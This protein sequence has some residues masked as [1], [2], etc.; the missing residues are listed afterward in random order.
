M[1]PPISIGTVLQNRYRVLQVL[2]QGG[3]G[4]TYL[5]AD[6]GRFNEYC[7]LKEFIP[8]QTSDYAVAKSNELFEREASV[9]YQI[10]HPQVPKFQAIFEQDQRLFLIQD[11]VEGKSYNAL[12]GERIA[13]G[14]AFTPEETQRFVQQLLPVLAHIHSKGIIHRD[15]SPDNVMLRQ[16]D[17]QPVL[18]DFGV[19]KAVAT[20]LQSDMGGGPTTVGK[21]GYAPNEQMQGG[22]VYPSSDLYALAVTAIVLMTGRQPTELFDS[23][24][25][26]WRWRQL[27]PNLMEPFASVLDRML[28]LRPSDRYQSAGDVMQALQQSWGATAIPPTLAGGPVAGTP[29]PGIP[30]QPTMQSPPAPAASQVKTIAVGHPSESGY[31]SGGYGS[32]DYGSGGY[33][34]GGPAGPTGPYAPE[35][36]GGQLPRRPTIDPRPSS[37]FDDPLAVAAVGIGAVALAGVG[38]WTLKSIM[39]GPPSTPIGTVT[40]TTIVQSTLPPTTPPATLTATPNA[41]EEPRVYKQALDLVPGQPQEV[42]TNLR[43]NATL[44]YEF[45]G[46]QDQT[47]SAY[48]KSEG[49]LLSVLGPDGQPVGD[50]AS[51]VS[52]WEGKLPYT[53]RYAIELKPVSGAS[54]RDFTLDLGLSDPP[55]PEVVET[56]TPDPVKT[57]P[58]ETPPEVPASP[59]YSDETVPLSPGTEDIR[60]GNVSPNR[61]KR[62]QVRLE[63]GQRLAARLVEGDGV[64][65]RF[66]GTDGQP[67]P[68]TIDI[69]QGA[70]QAATPGLYT[71]EV[72]GAKP[73][74]FAV[75]IRLDSLPE[76]PGAAPTP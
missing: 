35:P 51:R 25:F 57:T 53:G 50:R 55:P 1:Q 9:L 30:A 39:S 26:M 65:M 22:Q 15:I 71:I 75:S 16:Q 7:A 40:P 43:E 5:A 41:P 73:E 42:R 34:S 19:V 63:T 8:P 31:G 21:P 28:N 36:T 38:A 12:L 20:Q 67:I 59:T 62:Y 17:G 61:I 49:V 32:G 23:S 4:R 45:D 44:I 2:G 37:F 46:Q 72:I 70:I 74:P 14:R 47:L 48:M 68:G 60:Q 11:Y 13:A 6:Q 10:Q 27:V 76:D 29:P 3:F 18:I 24:T 56:P 64:S 54:A 66:N 58:T 52:G 69:A 33:G